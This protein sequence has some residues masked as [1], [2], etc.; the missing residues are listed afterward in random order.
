[1]DETVAELNG[2]RIPLRL[3]RRQYTLKRLQQL[4]E[5]SKSQ[6]ASR[7][8]REELIHVLSEIIKYLYCR[9]HIS[10]LQST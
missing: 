5:M 10:G 8:R 4:Y 7:E 1:M 3:V 2:N 9:R 6:F